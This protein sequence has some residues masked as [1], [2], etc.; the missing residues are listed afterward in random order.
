MTMYNETQENI[1][2]IMISVNRIDGIYYK[3]AKRIGI[4]ENTLSLFYALS[5]GK[6]HSQKEICD[7]WLVPRSTIN[8]IVHECVENG[9][10]RFQRSTRSK[11]KVLLLTE[12]GKKYADELMNELFSVEQAA[13]LETLKRYDDGFVQAVSFFADEL[14]RQA[15]HENDI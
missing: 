3:I 8:T 6:P 13:F 5:D 4:K 15:L 12:N 14:E 11:M 7:E 1:R 2:K 9:Y 10:V